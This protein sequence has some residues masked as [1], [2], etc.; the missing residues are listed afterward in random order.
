MHFLPSVELLLTLLNL[1]SRCVPLI[2]RW[3]YFYFL[4]CL[5][6]IISHTIRNILTAWPET[7][8]NTWIMTLLGNSR[9]EHQNN[10]N[11]N[12]NGT[13]WSAQTNNNN[14]IG[15]MKNHCWSFGCLGKKAHSPFSSFIVLDVFAPV[16][17]SKYLTITYVYQWRNAEHWGIRIGWC[18]DT[19]LCRA[20]LTHHL[21][22]DVRRNDL[23][24][25]GLMWLL[26]NVFGAFFSTDASNAMRAHT[27]YIVH[28][29]SPFTLCLTFSCMYLIFNWRTTHEHL[30]S[31]KV[32]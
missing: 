26:L 18:A 23:T 29:A 10:P 3:F 24:S 20:L 31:N 21:S 12:V 14:K 19:D 30:S 17:D 13:V 15:A 22:H 8:M 25:S 4:G 1:H 28:Y 32:H 2:S 6:S 5:I 11:D 27:N 16:K 7:H 9:T